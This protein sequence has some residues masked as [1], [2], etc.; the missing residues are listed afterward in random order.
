MATVKCPMIMPV[1][2][3]HVIFNLSI[4]VVVAMS[5]K[6]CFMD[7]MKARHTLDLTSTEMGRGLKVLHL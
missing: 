6:Y 2:N 7:D 5:G 4:I 1:M 3:M